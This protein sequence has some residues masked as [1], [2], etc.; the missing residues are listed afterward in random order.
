M[1]RRGLVGGERLADLIV[2]AEG[3]PGLNL[4]YENRRTTTFFRA[5]C[6]VLIKA[7]LNSSL[8]EDLLDN[9]FLNAVQ[10][11]GGGM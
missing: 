9:Y 3:A 10:I 1:K 4:A 7:T 5:P 2:C 6:C 8:T 11:D